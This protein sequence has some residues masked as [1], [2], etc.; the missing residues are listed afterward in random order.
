MVLVKLT[1]ASYHKQ[2]RELVNGFGDDY[3]VHQYT[4]GDDLVENGELNYA[5]KSN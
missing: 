4:I 1:S 3:E 2:L 5:E